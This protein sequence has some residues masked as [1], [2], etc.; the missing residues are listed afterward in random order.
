[1]SQN[2]LS[3][4]VVIGALRVKVPNRCINMGLCL[5]NNDCKICSTDSYAIISM[6][7]VRTIQII[8]T[9]LLYEL[10]FTGT[11]VSGLALL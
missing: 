3:A 11:W 9:A 5:L 1:M 6:V 10:A 4:A 7:Y 2:L 8:N